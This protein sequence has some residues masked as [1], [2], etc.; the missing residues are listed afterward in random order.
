MTSGKNIKAG[1]DNQKTKEV[2]NN[3]PKETESQEQNS[4]TTAIKESIASR[5]KL[6]IPEENKLPDGF[7]KVNGDLCFHGIINIGPDGK[8][9]EDIIRVKEVI[10]LSRYRYVDDLSITNPG[11]LKDNYIVTHEGRYVVCHVNEDIWNELVNMNPNG[12]K[13]GYVYIDL[14]ANRFAYRFNYPDWPTLEELK[15]LLDEHNNLFKKS[16]KSMTISVNKEA[17]SA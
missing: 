6:S 1:Q 2:E 5:S 12:I 11:V 9:L 8:P 15:D 7:F 13:P 17:E 10:N 4:E 14:A 3:N 16:Y